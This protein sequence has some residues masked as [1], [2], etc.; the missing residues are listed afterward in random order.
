MLAP[1]MARN[2]AVKVRYR[3]RTVGQRTGWSV[4]RKFRLLCAYATWDVHREL[5]SEGII[6]KIFI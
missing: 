5:E 2:L 1:R 3:S 4:G 6:K